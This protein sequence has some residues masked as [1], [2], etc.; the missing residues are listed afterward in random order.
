MPRIAGHIIAPPTPI[1]KRAPSSTQMF[2]AKPP[3]TE[4]TREDRGADHEHRAPAEHVGEPA[5]GDDQDAEHHGVAVDHPL[6][7]GEVDAEFRLDRGNRDRERG[8][9]VGDDQH[10]DAH[11]DEA[12]NL[13]PRQLPVRRCHRLP[14]DSVNR[15]GE[16]WHRRRARCDPGRRPSGGGQPGRW[17][18]GASGSTAASSFAAFRLPRRQP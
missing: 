14:P 11:R 10:R 8:E 1:R 16:V 6:R 2:G 7:R 9:V 18:D 12:E 3:I 15:A 5:A 13:L 17:I 4:K